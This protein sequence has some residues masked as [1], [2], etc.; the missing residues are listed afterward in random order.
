[1]LDPS[2]AA[3]A[4]AAA[5]AAAAATDAPRL[6]PR[7][8]T[9]ALLPITGVTLL[10]SLLR[11]YLGA[12]LASPPRRTVAATADC[13]A[14]ARSAALRRSAGSLPPEQ[15]AP[16][17]AAAAAAAAA[18][19]DRPRRSLIASMLEPDALS[20]KVWGLAA[21]VLP[22]AA[23]GAWVRATYGRLAVARLPFPLS[24]PYRAALQA[25]MERTTG[26]DLDVATVSALSWYVL[27]IFGSGGVAT[28][29]LAADAAMAAK[30]GRGKG[31]GEGGRPHPAHGLDSGTLGFIDTPASL[32]SVSKAFAVEA[33]ALAMVRHRWTAP[34]AEDEL[35]KEPY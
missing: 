35:L 30:G 20:A 4:A 6:D 33:E 10:V 29:L 24:P 13:Q 31:G 12:L 28:L 22:Q 34:D 7:I 3:T 9:W 16:R 14:L 18:A 19:R 2:P 21:S 15:Y 26:G 32:P 11:S 8:R 23:A 1:M 25:G 27:T 17:A 5:A